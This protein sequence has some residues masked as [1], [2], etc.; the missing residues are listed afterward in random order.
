[1]TAAIRSES[2]I[3]YG[4]LTVGGTTNRLISGAIV[5]SETYPTFLVSFEFTTNATTEALWITE[6][7]AVMTAFRTPRQ[8]L[9]ILL[10]QTSGSPS[11]F[12]DYNPSATVN[13]GFDAESE[14]SQ[15]EG[16]IENTARSGRFRVTV[17][18]TLPADLS[19]QSGLRT[20]T[21][22]IDYEPSRRRRI[23]ITG[24]YTALTTATASAQYVASIVTYATAAIDAIGGTYNL[25]TESRS[26]NDTDK[27]MSFTRVYREITLDESSGTANDTGV[28]RQELVV[29]RTFSAPGDSPVS[30][31]STPGSGAIAGTAFGGNPAA[32][33]L[34]SISRSINNPS[35]AG[36]GVQSVG[37]A[38]SG[39]SSGGNVPRRLI[40][41][42]VRY[43]A[44]LDRD[45]TTD[46][47]A[48]WTTKLRA[49]VIAQAKAQAQVSSVA[50]IDESPSFDYENNVV[51]AGL[52]LQAV[53]ESNILMAT[54]DETLD[55]TAGLLPTAVWIGRP[56][57]YAVF[58][59]PPRTAI[60][61]TIRYTAVEGT[62]A[63][64]PSVPPEGFIRLRRTS[65]PRYF[66]I[67]RAGY[68]IRLVER[69]VSEEWLKAEPYPLNASA[70]DA[71]DGGVRGSVSRSKR[72]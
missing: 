38:S 56:H 70:P 69:T 20:A 5:S 41:V 62:A 13:T 35:L 27:T 39:G 43:Q 66:V 49:H 30:G 37:A 3:I 57:V 44:T 53:G 64:F 29:T 33:V 31:G 1:M 51:A 47:R 4:G 46:P 50:L 9:R 24:E 67:G 34:A 54:V 6:K 23:T 12:R 71:R 32:E 14:I 58:P 2:S 42:R 10:E 45:V 55:E 59:G 52:L 11:T 18:G 19:G 16:A 40:D 48:Y 68:E 25:D 61:R 8:R 17:R 65:R 15:V 72:V 22:A 7:Q 28:I 63:D 60:I 21:V 26:R 36:A